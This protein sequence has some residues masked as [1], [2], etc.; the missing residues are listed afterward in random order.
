M[1]SLKNSIAFA[2]HEL[3][4]GFLDSDEELEE[5][6]ELLAVVADRILDSL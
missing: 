5:E 6:G 4:E 2:K 3:D 1:K